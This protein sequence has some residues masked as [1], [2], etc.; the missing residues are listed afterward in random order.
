MEWSSYIGRRRSVKKAKGRVAI[1]AVL[2][3]REGRGWLD[4]VLTPASSS[5]LSFFHDK[6][7]KVLWK[8]CGWMDVVSINGI[9]SLPELLDWCCGLVVVL[10]GLQHR[11][12]PNP[13]KFPH[14]I[15]I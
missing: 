3:N 5:F 10:H 9:Y 15:T 6:R 12:V 2:A 14:S 8:R 4:P 11:M 1:L 7:V 13:T